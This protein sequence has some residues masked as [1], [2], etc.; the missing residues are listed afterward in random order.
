MQSRQEREEVDELLR[1]RANELKAL[2][3]YGGIDNDDDDDDE[4]DDEDHS[5]EPEEWIN[6]NV[7]HAVE[8][9]DIDTPSFAVGL[10]TLA[11]TTKTTKSRKRRLVTLAEDVNVNKKAKTSLAEHVPLVSVKVGDGLSPEFRLLD[12]LPSDMNKLIF[13]FLNIADH[14]A[15]GKCSKYLTTISLDPC[16]WTHLD[17]QSLG[18]RLTISNLFRF[19]HIKPKKLILAHATV[20]GL[21]VQMEILINK[22]SQGSVCVPSGHNSSDDTTNSK[23][24]TSL[25][26][27]DATGSF[28]WFGDDEAKC[29]GRAQ[30]QNS[31]HTL[32]L[33]FTS[34]SDQGMK[35]L[36]DLRLC[37]LDTGSM[38]K[39]TNTG[40]AL[41]NK[42]RLA[43]LG[44]ADQLTVSGICGHKLVSVPSLRFMKIRNVT[45]C[46]FLEMV[47]PSTGSPTTNEKNMDISSTNMAKRFTELFPNVFAVAL[48]NN[49]MEAQSMNSFD[50]ATWLWILSNCK[51]ITHLDLSQMNCIGDPE[52]VY[53]EKSN[54]QYLAI[55]QAKITQGLITSLLK[56]KHL[57]VLHVPRYFVQGSFAKL[58]RSL[59]LKYF[60]AGL[61]K[62]ISLHG[63]LL[64]NNM[65]FKYIR[66]CN[67]HCCAQ[68][69]TFRQDLADTVPCYC[70]IDSEVDFITEQGIPL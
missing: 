20:C 16:T 9:D 18:P 29:L 30:V 19:R 55:T 25:C 44:V 39:I 34:V 68:L 17:L 13:T 35:Y 67:N 43:V 65:G 69:S 38:T 58:G 51:Q 3:F 41:L 60:N 10:N 61:C 14:F 49:K 56:M 42:T 12:K 70:I 27:L 28:G 5:F 1:E 15:I 36:Q 40:L 31:L 50:T 59:H 6:D 45:S 2:F 54:I 22:T 63:K 53:L 46:E 21:V 23:I 48:F 57:Q 47:K 8:E 11:E 64:Y 32:D 37:N 62:P 33:S 7:S 66:Y 26:I 4:N 52:L 24:E